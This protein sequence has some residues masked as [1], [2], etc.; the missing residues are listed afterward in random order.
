MKTPDSIL[1]ISQSCAKVATSFVAEF[2]VNT[3]T[4]TFLEMYP[5]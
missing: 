2:Y 4:L 5:W 1:Y 3:F